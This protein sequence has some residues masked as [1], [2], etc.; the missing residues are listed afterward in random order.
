[1]NKKWNNNDDYSEDDFLKQKLFIHG[2]NPKTNIIK[3]GAKAP[4]KERLS[5]LKAYS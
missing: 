2:S 5:N 3:K 1:M 4:F